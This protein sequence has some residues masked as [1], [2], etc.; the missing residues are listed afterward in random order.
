M[1]GRHS[2]V[3]GENHDEA[4]MLIL[5]ATVSPA[6]SGLGYLSVALFFG[7]TDVG[8]GVAL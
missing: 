2:L 1:V 7:G 3:F 8:S 6:T 4:W 5:F